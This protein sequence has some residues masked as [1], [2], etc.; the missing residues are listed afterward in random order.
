VGV[1]A[2]WHDSRRGRRDSI[3]RW[4]KPFADAEPAVAAEV[5]RLYA[6]ASGAA[7]LEQMVQFGHRRAFDPA[8][9]SLLDGLKAADALVPRGVAVDADVERLKA[10]MED[11]LRVMRELRRKSL[12]PY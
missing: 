6:L 9:A 2:S 1:A 11:C 12:Q 8:V 4:V 7:S 5:R 3:L 10:I